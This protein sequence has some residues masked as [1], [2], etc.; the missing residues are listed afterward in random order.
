MDWFSDTAVYC[1][2]AFIAKIT[3]WLL[4][5][6]ISMIPLVPIRIDSDGHDTPY[7]DHQSN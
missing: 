1:P 5:V 6:H 2:S 4:N 7:S 3:I